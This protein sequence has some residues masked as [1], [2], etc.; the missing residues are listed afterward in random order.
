MRTVRSLSSQHHSHF[1]ALFD[2]NNEI[3]VQAQYY[4]VAQYP[5]LAGPQV[6][7]ESL[8]TYLATTG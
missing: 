1:L 8:K 5:S 7:T 6:F 4:S 3:H 2:M